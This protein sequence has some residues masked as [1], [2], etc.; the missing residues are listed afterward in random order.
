MSKPNSKKGHEPK[1]N[2]SEFI[3]KYRELEKL[4]ED[5]INWIS[6]QKSFE[7]AVKHTES[8]YRE[9]KNRDYQE[10]LTKDQQIKQDAYLYESD[11]SNHEL[12]FIVEQSAYF[13]EPEIHNNRWEIISE[14]GTRGLVE[15]STNQWFPFN[16]TTFAI[17]WYRKI[18]VDKTH[19]FVE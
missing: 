5:G 2:V 15:I 1:I 4:D 6:V 10:K 13:S 9:K 8:H 16:S 17:E 12:N 18:L 19:R 7:E 14:C 3:K 11:F